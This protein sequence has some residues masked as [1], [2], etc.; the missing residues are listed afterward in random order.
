M[1]KKA[2]KVGLVGAG[3][4]GG[5]VVELYRR[6]GGLINERSGFV[7]ELEKVVDL[8]EARLKM[9][10][11]D[12]GK[13]ST[14]AADVLD[15]P[16]ID[17][18][19]ELIGGINP[20]YKFIKRALENGKHVVTANKDL[21]AT[22]GEELLELARKKDLNV[23]YEAS[24]GGGIP[25]IRPMKHNLVADRVNRLIGIVNGTTNYIFTRM[26]LDDLSLQDALNE[27]QKFGFAEP[28]P[29]NDIE[30][31]DAAYKLVIMSNLAFGK[32]A[33]FEKVHI[34]GISGITYE[35]IAYARDWLYN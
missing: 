21:M 27:A 19:I 34:E 32:K 35:D 11:L 13:T 28:D 15:N 10:G 14:D 29:T 17:I 20:A 26:A 23:F 8:D 5:G 1:G 9:L 33:E 7:I 2:V 3:T 6:N 16:D 31:F 24:V 25:L 4:I 18:V 22:H 12:N 30:G